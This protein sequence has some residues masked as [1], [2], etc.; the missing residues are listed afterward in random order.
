MN[1]KSLDKKNTL[2]HESAEAHFDMRRAHIHK[3]AD[4]ASQA[5]DSTTNGSLASGAFL[6]TPLIWWEII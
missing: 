5:K 3:G 1:L 4:I 2:Q 6:S